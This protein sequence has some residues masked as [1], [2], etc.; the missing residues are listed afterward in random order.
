MDVFKKLIEVKNEVMEKM[1][2]NKEIIFND[3]CQ[4]GCQK[5][6]LQIEC[7]KLYQNS[8]SGC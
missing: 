6:C 5:E 2:E 1:K 4:I 7:Q 3:R 8:V